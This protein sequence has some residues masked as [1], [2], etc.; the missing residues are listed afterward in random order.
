M[1]K[2]MILKSEKK[3]TL[4]VNNETHDVMVYYAQKHRLTLQEATQKLLSIALE[5][6]L[7]DVKG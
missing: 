5:K 2:P 6:E 4:V 3:C 7:E 1:P